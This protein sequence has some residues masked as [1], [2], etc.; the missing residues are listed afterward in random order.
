MD[1][2]A[3]SRFSGFALAFDRLAKS[4]A[5]NFNAYSSNYH[6]LVVVLLLVVQVRDQLIQAMRNSD[7]R[8]RIVFVHRLNSDLHSKF[9][10]QATG[11]NFQYGP[12]FGVPFDPTFWFR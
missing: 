6:L 9:T 5:F 12:N 7:P 3:E 4:P 8:V 1:E 11:C 10:L 2:P